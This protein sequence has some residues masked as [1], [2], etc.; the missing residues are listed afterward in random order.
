MYMEI[1]Q[2]ELV[3]RRTGGLEMPRE[4]WNALKP[5]PRRTGGLEI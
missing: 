5:V 2:I 1:K 4:Y 3:P